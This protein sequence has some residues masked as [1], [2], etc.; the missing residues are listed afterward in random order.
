MKYFVAFFVFYVCIIQ[1]SLA[2]TPPEPRPFPQG[3]TS[4]EQLRKNKD[5]ERADSM[6]PDD[7]QPS[8]E[9]WLPPEFQ[10]TEQKWPLLIFSHGFGGCAKQAAFLTEYLADQGYIV[11]APEHDDARCRGYLGGGR[12]QDV[13]GT[14]DW[15]EKP[16]RS[17]ESWTDKTEADRKDDVIFALESMLDD[18]EY[19]DF[20]DTDRMGLIGYSLGG[21]TV[22]GI[23]GG[24]SSWKDKRFK[25]VLALSPYTGPYLRNRGLK[26]VAVP[27]MYQG[28]TKDDPITPAVMRRGGA[29][30]MTQAPKYFVEYQGAGHFSFTEAER[31]YHDIIRRTSLDFLNRYVKGDAVGIDADKKPQ[32]KTF[33][34]DEVGTPKE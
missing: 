33:W 31:G 1:P 30:D 22:L 15:P 19:R 3:T 29:Y 21:Y 5:V 32:V 9:M 18:R 27:V 4:F 13:R 11:I 14:K 23:A 17:P 8:V 26:A 28:G 25:A 34:K 24:W 6:T 20:I 2:Q 7:R 12:L 10:S 16:F